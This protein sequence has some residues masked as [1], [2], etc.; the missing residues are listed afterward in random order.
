MRMHKKIYPFS[1]CFDLWHVVRLGHP[2]NFVV[3]KFLRKSS[4][5]LISLAQ[6]VCVLNK[7]GIFFIQVLIIHSK[8]LIWYTV[9]FGG[10]TMLHLLVA[11]NI[12]LLYWTITLDLCRFICLYEKR[13]VVDILRKFLAMVHTQFHKTVKTVR[14]DNNTEFV[15]PKNYFDEKDIVYQATVVGPP[16]KWTCRMQALS[17]PQCSSCSTFWSKSTY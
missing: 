16:T 10:P 17:H 14:T 12:F 5:I 2:S 9:I 6:S 11:Q 15:C 8:D 3:D 13:E 7:L 4:L 1:V